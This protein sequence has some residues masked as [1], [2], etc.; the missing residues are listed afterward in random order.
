VARSC[1]DTSVPHVGSRRPPARPYTRSPGSC[2]DNGLGCDVCPRRDLAQDRHLP[3]VSGRLA[4]HACLRVVAQDRVRIASEIWSPTCPLVGCDPRSPTQFVNRYWAASTMSSSCGSSAG[5][6]DRG[7]PVARPWA[8]SRPAHQP[9]AAVGGVRSG[10]AT[11]VGL[12]AGFSPA[13]ESDAASA[14]L[15]A[16][17]AAAR[18]STRP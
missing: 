13:A 8:P 10:R 5:G 7:W 14:G 15:P 2:S 12:P 11:P 17:T 9:P 6:V 18:S 4:R 3:V 1:T 16:P